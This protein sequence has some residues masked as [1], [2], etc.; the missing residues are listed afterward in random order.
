MPGSIGRD[1]LYPALD[2]PSPKLSFA[3]HRARDICATRAPLFEDGDTLGPATKT[4]RGNELVIAPRHE[5]HQGA[6]NVGY[7]S[8]L[9]G[10]EVSIDADRLKAFDFRETPGELRYDD[11]IA[12]FSKHQ[13]ARR[14]GH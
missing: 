10:W 1:C 12:P 8:N 11:V 5:L 7:L 3:C 9:P 6:S 4:Q 13:M 14:I 2:C